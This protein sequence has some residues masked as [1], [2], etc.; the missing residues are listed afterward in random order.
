MHECVRLS[1][2]FIGPSSSALFCTLRWDTA[3]GLGDALGEEEA[4]GAG[5]DVSAEDVDEL[6]KRAA[7]VGKPPQKQEEKGYLSDDDIDDF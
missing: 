1:N 5:V 2:A 6:E 4:V 7:R 3:T